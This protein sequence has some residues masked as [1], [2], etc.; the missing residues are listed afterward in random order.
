[1]KIHPIY[2]LNVC[3]KSTSITIYYYILLHQP[4]HFCRPTLKLIKTQLDI[5]IGVWII[6]KK[7]KP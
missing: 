1:M 7:N 5:S 4:Y 3:H 6:A 2:F